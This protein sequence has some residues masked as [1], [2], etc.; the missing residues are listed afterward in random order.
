METSFRNATTEVPYAVASCTNRIGSDDTGGRRRVHRSIGRPELPRP[1][2]HHGRRRGPRPLRRVVG[3]DHAPPQPCGRWTPPPA[4]AEKIGTARPRYDLQAAGDYYVAEYSTDSGSAVMAVQIS[5]GEEI[6]I[7]ERDVTLGGRYDRVFVLDGTDAIVPHGRRT[8]RVRPGRA[9]LA[10]RSPWTRIYRGYSPPATATRWSNAAYVYSGDNLLVDLAT[11]DAAEVPALPEG[12]E[13]YFGECGHRGRHA[14]HFGA[15]LQ[16]PERDR[17][18]HLRAGHRL[19]NLEQPDL[20]RPRLDRRRHLPE[21]HRQEQA[22]LDIAAT[23]LAYVRG[24]SDAH[25]LVEF[26]DTWQE[27]RLDLLDR[28]TGELTA[29]ARR[30][31]IPSRSNTAGYCTMDA[32]TGSTRRSRRSSSTTVASGEEDVVTLNVPPTN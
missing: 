13:A 19:G 14:R 32:F 12:R 31:G 9:Y 3:V 7:L 6:T 4:R 8:P 16:W 5:T 25:V 1:G 18:R 10:G 22:R 20:L 11:G 24:A 17:P 15:A 26:V 2:G 30:A 27:S 23:R 21:R 28:T 29:I